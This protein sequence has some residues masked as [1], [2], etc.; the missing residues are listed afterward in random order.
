MYY[1]EIATKSGHKISAKRRSLIVRC[2]LLFGLC[3]TRHALALCPELSH[4]RD[5]AR[6]NRGVTLVVL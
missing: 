1:C 2:C 6:E 3:Q 5:F 4:D